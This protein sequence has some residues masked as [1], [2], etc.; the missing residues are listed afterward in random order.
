MSNKRILPAVILAATVGFLGLHRFY[1]GRPYTALMQLAAFLA[2]GAMLWKDVASLVKLQTLDDF[3]DWS[4]SHPIQ[5]IPWL[6][7][8]ISAFWA[9]IDCGILLRRKFRDG[10]GNTMTR[11]I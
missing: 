9:L 1:V 5:P 7:V 2:G 10:A 4:Q 3:M 8:G 6:L 11:W